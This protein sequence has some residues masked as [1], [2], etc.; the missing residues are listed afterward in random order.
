MQGVQ[1]QAWET[2]CNGRKPPGQATLPWGKGDETPASGA[3]EMKTGK[4]A[5]RKA[6]NL[7]SDHS[8][9]LRFLIPE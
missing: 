4:Q 2:G 5:G 1:K 8:A 3:E 6:Y 9:L 7:L